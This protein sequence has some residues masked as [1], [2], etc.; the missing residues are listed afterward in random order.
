MLSQGRYLGEY[1]MEVGIVASVGYFVWLAY[2]QI[3]HN[4]LP[5]HKGFEPEPVSP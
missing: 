1:L 2:R 5:V 3:K 4:A